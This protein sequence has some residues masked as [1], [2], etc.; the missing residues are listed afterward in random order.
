MGI[1]D[2]GTAGLAVFLSGGVQFLHNDLL[3]PLGAVQQVLQIVDLVPQGI[4]LP[5]PLENV[6]FIDVPQLDLR[7][8][9]R[10]DLVDAEADHQVGDDLGLLLRL[11]DDGDGL[12]DIQQDALQTQQ[13]MQLL[14][15][16]GE[17]EVYPP[18]HALRAP[19][20]PLLQ[21]GLDSQHTGH[22]GD[23]DVEVTAEGVLQRR[24]L[25]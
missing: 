9:F 22:P 23:E 1:D 18:P 15:L 3:H 14:L 16:A 2:G 4:R 25:I 21:Q 11:P 17:D 24:Q 10:L 20:D 6:L 8:I 7:H 19:C 12:V 5:G 13:Q